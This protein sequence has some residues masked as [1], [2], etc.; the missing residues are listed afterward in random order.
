[1]NSLSKRSGVVFKQLG[2]LVPTWLTG[3]AETWYYSQSAETRE[4][5]EVDWAS[6]T[7]IGEYYMNQT[8]LDKQKARANRASYRDVGNGRELPSEYVIHKSELLQFV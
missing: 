5:I 8:F 3:S 2:T 1:M 7:A 4:R 6:L